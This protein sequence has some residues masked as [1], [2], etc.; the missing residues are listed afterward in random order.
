MSGHDYICKENG[1]YLYF[2]DFC[3]WVLELFCEMFVLVF[4]LIIYNVHSGKPKHNVSW[5]TINNTIHVSHGVLIVN[6]DILKI[7]LYK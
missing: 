3:A 2:N 7:V 6:F 4:N 1:F 5:L